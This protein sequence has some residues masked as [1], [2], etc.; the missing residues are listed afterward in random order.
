L[1]SREVIV[2]L[3]ANTTTATGLRVQAEIDTN[4][5]QTGIRI[6]KKQMDTVNLYPAD[7]HGDWNYS[8][9]PSTAMV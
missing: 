3:I 8:I 4:R 9:R 2:E 6:T 5:Y 7:F 1:I